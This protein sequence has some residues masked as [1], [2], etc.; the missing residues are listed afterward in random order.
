MIRIPAHVT[1]RQLHLNV[2]ILHSG[3]VPSAWRLDDADPRAF[4]DVDHYVRVAQ[5]AEAARLDAVFLADNAAIVD[6]ID[7]LQNQRDDL[8]LGIELQ[9][10][11]QPQNLVAEIFVEQVNCAESKREEQ[12]GL[13]QLEQTDSQ[14]AA[15]TMMVRLH[16]ADRSGLFSPGSVAGGFGLHHR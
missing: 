11:R 7:F 15:V 16:A 9:L 6:Q 8:A 1:P 14:K 13:A 5:I 12:N 4:I 3:F 10:T 2:N